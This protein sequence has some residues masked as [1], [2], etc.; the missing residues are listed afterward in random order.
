[1]QFVISCATVCEKIWY[2]LVL[3]PLTRLRHQASSASLFDNQY[4]YNPANQISQI[5]DLTQIKNFTFDNVDRLTGMTNGTSSESYTF[6]DVGNRTASHLSATYGYQSGKFNQL[7]STATA[8]YRFDANG[9]TTSKSEGLNFWRFT[10]DYENRMTEAT[11]RKQKVRYKYDALGRRVERNLGFSKKRTKFTHDGLDVVMDDDNN[12]GI[13]KYQ[14]GLGIDDKLKLSNAGSSSYF[15]QDHLGSTVGLADS[16]AV[17]NSSKAYD[18]FGN[19]TGNLASRYQYTGREFD[20]FTNQYYYRARFY[21][22]NLG[23][24]TSEDP[25]GFGGGDVN[26]Y[27]YVHNRPTMFRDPTGE[28]V[29]VLVAGGIAV[30]VLILASPSYVNAP[31][32]RS[33]VYYPDNPLLANAAGGAAC[34]YLLNRFVSPLIT[35]LLSGAGDDIISLGISGGP[36]R[37]GYAPNSPLPMQ[38]VGGVDIP[39]PHPNAQGPHTT[40]G[41]RVGSDG[42]PYRQSATFPGETW[43]TANGQQVPWGRTDWTTHGRGDHLFPHQHPLFL[44]SDGT[45]RYGPMMG[46]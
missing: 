33:P 23:R 39:L 12:A 45:W 22:S 34:G 21:D 18:S 26:L 17:I 7:S 46:F 15:L 10:W 1:M 42:I 36:T 30:A 40:L 38:K 27:G 16:T 35:R 13:T 6:D 37:G 9:N 24:F 29:P 41:T 25:I 4:S 20:S 19:S 8:N 3:I 43:P 28:I 14:N 44:Q 31:G 2:A 32:P 5:A 11:A